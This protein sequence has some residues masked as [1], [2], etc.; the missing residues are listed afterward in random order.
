MHC[1]QC[2]LEKQCTI[3]HVIRRHQKAVSCLGWDKSISDTRRL[4]LLTV[5][6]GSQ[7]Q[8]A[9]GPHAEVDYPTLARE[10]QGFRVWGKFVF[11]TLELTDT[12]TN[13]ANQVKVG[14]ALDQSRSVQSRWPEGASAPKQWAVMAIVEGRSSTFE[15]IN[16]LYLLL[17]V[18][19]KNKNPFWMASLTLIFTRSVELRT[20]KAVR[21]SGLQSVNWPREDQCHRSHADGFLLQYSARRTTDQYSGVPNSRTY[22]NKRTPD[23]ICWKGNNR[24]PVLHYIYYNR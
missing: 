23:K 4:S 13:L 12:P 15:T 2:T 8:L 17:K 1:V 16:R 24:T 14:H 20:H 18:W 3:Y 11:R 21:P 9:A 6:I 5:S 10:F 19:D 7:S 22:G